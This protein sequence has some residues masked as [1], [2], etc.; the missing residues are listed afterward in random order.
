[1]PVL[2][3]LSLAPPQFLGGDQIVQAISAENQEEGHGDLDQGGTEYRVYSG[4][5]L[6]TAQDVEQVVVAVREDKPVYVRDLA[7]VRMGPSEFDR[8]VWHYSGAA[9]TDEA[10][11]VN[12]AAA[13]TIAM[14][15][16][17]GSNG[18]DVANAVLAEL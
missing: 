15:K 14:A 3:P 9:K 10:P 13:V 17:Q 5:F 1:M 11:E 4:R 6:K 2:T 8:I 7:H 16:K 12:G 18:V